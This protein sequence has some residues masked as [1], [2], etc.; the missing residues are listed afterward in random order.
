M[1]FNE[2]LS[3][4]HHVCQLL[5][6]NYLLVRDTH[7]LYPPAQIVCKGTIWWEVMEPY[8]SLEGQTLT[9]EE[10]SLVKFPITIAYQ[11]RQAG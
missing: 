11:T 10:E 9:P 5:Y 4:C 7:W 1:V 2:C 8:S 3:S 6:E